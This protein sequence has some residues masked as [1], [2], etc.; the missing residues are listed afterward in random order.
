MVRSP[1]PLSYVILAAIGEHG[2][3]TPDLVDMASRGTMF[4]SS[5]PSQIYA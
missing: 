3:S 4:W 5:A 2:A 1:I